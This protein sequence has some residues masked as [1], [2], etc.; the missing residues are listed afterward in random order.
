[1]ENYSPNDLPII[2][3][4]SDRHAGNF[5]LQMHWRVLWVLWLMHVNKASM[6]F[7]RLI[8]RTVVRIHSMGQ[9]AKSI[10][11]ARKLK[12][13]STMRLCKKTADIHCVSVLDYTPM[14]EGGGVWRELSGNI[15]F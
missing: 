6:W 10:T 13:G 4:L 11:Q 9:C 2:S 5:A 8:P 3:D 7:I 12:T 15:D 1:M 14:T